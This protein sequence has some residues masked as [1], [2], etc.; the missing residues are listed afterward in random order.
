MAYHQRMGDL[1]VRVTAGLRVGFWDPTKFRPMGEPFKCVGF[2]AGRDLGEHTIGTVL[3]QKLMEGTLRF[4]VG[5]L[6]RPDLGRRQRI[7]TI[8]I[9]LNWI[10][11]MFEY[12]DWAKDENE[13]SLLGM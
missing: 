7:E 4:K 2:Y 5:F 13:L 1:D 10:P 11:E 12:E 8:L 3:T 9:L 6:F